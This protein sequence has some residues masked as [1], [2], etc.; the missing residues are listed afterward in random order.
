MRP[1]D[2]G[3]KFGKPS[4]AAEQK[5][6]R[7]IFNLGNGANLI[8]RELSASLSLP[9]PFSFSF[10]SLEVSEGKGKER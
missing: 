7:G 5:E 1:R 2:G 10:S 8:P 9:G 4:E 3:G 6:R